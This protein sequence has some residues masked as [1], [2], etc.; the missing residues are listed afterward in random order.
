MPSRSKFGW[1]LKIVGIVCFLGAAALVARMYRLTVV[2]GAELTRQ[3][4]SITC[5]TASRP[6]TEDR[7][8]IATARRSRPRWSRSKSPCVAASTRTARAHAA[9]LAEALSLDRGDPRQ[10]ASRRSA[11]VHLALASRGDG[12]RQPRSASFASAGIDV[13]A[14]QRR[15]YPHGSLAAHVI[16]FSGVDEQ[17]MEGIERVLDEE[18][19]G[20]SITRKG[21][22]GRAR[23]RVARP[24]RAARA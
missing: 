5:R 1:R 8:S 23:P 9:L 4:R 22:Q 18:I 19:R 20:E 6:R 24:R 13:V 21:L 15:A 16:G 2:E 14:D 3:A 17:G 10:D 11:K 12:C 7:S